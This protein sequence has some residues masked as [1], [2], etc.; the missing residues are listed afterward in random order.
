MDQ[1]WTNMDQEMRERIIEL[2][3]QAKGAGDFRDKIPALQFPRN[4]KI[5]MSPNFGGTTVRFRVGK[6]GKTGTVS[7]YLDC[8]DNVGHMGRPYWEVYPLFGD[9]ARSYMDN[10]VKLIKDIRHGLSGLP[11]TR[12][13]K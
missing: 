3:G 2:T 8:H 5:T 4:W 12:E 13:G 10:T 1:E 11:N 6:E 7:V 9:T